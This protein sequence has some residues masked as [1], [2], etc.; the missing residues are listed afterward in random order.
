[1]EF[2]QPGAE[3]VPGV[4]AQAATGHSPGH[5]VF[6]V[7]DGGQ[8]VMVSGDAIHAPSFFWAHPDWHIGFDTDPADAV[9]TRKRL[10]DQLATDRMPVIVYHASMAAV[11]GRAERS[12]TG[13]RLVPGIG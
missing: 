13:Y 10:L 7:S 3:V 9:A 6:V 11:A 8:S 5:S 1:M 2:F 4:T 12:G